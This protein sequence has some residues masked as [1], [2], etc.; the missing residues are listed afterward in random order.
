MLIGHPSADCPLSRAA[1]APGM[2]SSSAWYRATHWLGLHAKQ[3]F[4]FYV[5][6]PTSE[7]G[8]NVEVQREGANV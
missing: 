2:S 3:A 8:P 7:V 4:K 6:V 1:F 5:E